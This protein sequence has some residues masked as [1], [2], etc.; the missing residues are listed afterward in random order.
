M[1]PKVAKWL[2]DQATNILRNVAGLPPSF[3]AIWDAA[4]WGSA[5]SVDAQRLLRMASGQ[6][7]LDPSILPP[8]LG[9]QPPGGSQPPGSQPP[10]GQLPGGG[11][12]PGTVG[13]TVS[14]GFAPGEE[15]NVGGGIEQAE[16]ELQAL[17]LAQRVALERSRQQQAWEIAR[18]QG[19]QEWGLT[20]ADLASREMQA[21]RSLGFDMLDYV[22]ETMRD[23]FSIVPA[24]QMYGAAGG[25]P[26]SP[27]QALALTQL[28]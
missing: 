16:L 10:S 19:L 6:E 12:L 4:R 23:P 24:L 5:T 15:F 28:E 22:T 20:E 2:R 17:E 9:G 21:R 26:L 25:G 13:P 8:D 18:R 3:P 11:Q 14:P 7:P 1:P 27:A